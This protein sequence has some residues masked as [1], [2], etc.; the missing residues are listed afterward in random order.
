MEAGRRGGRED[1]RQW[2]WEGGK[3][4]TIVALVMGCSG[5]FV[6]RYILHCFITRFVIF[7]NLSIFLYTSY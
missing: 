1:G 3:R 6:F 5:F 2:N 4:E 7:A